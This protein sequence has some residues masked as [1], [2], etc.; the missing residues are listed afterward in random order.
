MERHV[1]VVEM[2]F[3]GKWKP[4]ISCSLTRT[5]ARE[6]KDDWET[7]NHSYKFRVVKYVPENNILTLNCNWTFDAPSE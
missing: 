7:R 2:N 3:D 1:W 5:E 6:E 4:T